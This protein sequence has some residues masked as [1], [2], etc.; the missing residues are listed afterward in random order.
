VSAYRAVYGTE[1]H[2]S[3]EMI[4]AR[5]QLEAGGE[6][7]RTFAH[8]RSVALPAGGSITIAEAIVGDPLQEERLAWYWYDIGGR[9]TSSPYQAKALEVWFFLKGEAPLQRVTVISTPLFTESR[10]R[11]LVDEFLRVHAAALL[12]P[13]SAAAGAGCGG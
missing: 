10:S 13:S 7:R 8:E 4:A 12:A 3:A 1:A 11:T 9:R 2:G 5:N 6:E